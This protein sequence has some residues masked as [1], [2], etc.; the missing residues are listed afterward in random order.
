MEQ[1]IGEIAFTTWTEVHFE[2]AKR[3]LSNSGA[4]VWFEECVCM[5]RILYTSKKLKIW[6]VKLS[7]IFTPSCA[8]WKRQP[9]AVK[10]C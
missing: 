1:V 9:N 5:K 3:Y 4:C 10:I 6:V 8:K 7:Y 2:G